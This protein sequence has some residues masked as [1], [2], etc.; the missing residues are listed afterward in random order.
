MTTGQLI[1]IA[2]AIFAASFVQIIAGF[3]FALMCMPIMVIAVPVEQAVVVSALI[4]LLTTTWQAIHLREHTQ[5]RLLRRLVPAAYI[6]MPLGL[7]ILNVVSDYALQLT[8]GVSV[9]LAVVL[10]ARNV[11]LSH[12]GQRM[13][14]GLGFVS[15]VL[16][17]SLGTNGPPL[18]F[19][20][21]ARRLSADRFRGT[22]SATFALCNIG[23]MLLFLLDGKVT[24]R[25]V[26][27]AIVALPAW[28]VGQFLG[29]PVRQHVDG[30][31][32]R[33]LVLALLV[34]AGVSAIVFALT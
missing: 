25:G 19:D 23:G 32:F 7:V 31:R 4:S 10:L 20:L 14:F 27:A 21:Q 24:R 5:W 16:A 33:R 12:V 34:A 2:V 15:G 8:L 17:T 1:L 11:N 18:V 13:D 26:D 30:E 3:G 6:G 29:W 28:A 9:L 22:I